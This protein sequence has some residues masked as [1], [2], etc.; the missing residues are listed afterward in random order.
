[1]L[2]C[3]ACFGKGLRLSREVGNVM[4]RSRA[5]VL[6]FLERGGGAES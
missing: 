5:S 1:V 4:T 3:G 2:W 6:V